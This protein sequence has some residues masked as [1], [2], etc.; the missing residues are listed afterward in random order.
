M[1]VTIAPGTRAIPILLSGAIHLD[2]FLDSCDALFA[3]VPV[4]RRLEI[5]KDPHHGTF[6]LA[7]LAILTVWMAAALSAIDAAHLAAVL[8]FSG[9]TARLAGVSNAL[10]VPYAR[11]DAT[12]VL[13]QRPPFVPLAIEA[14]VLLL[15]GWLTAGLI[16]IALVPGA[17]VTSIGAGALLKRRLGGGLV[18]DVYGFLIVSLEAALLTVVAAG[19]WMAVH[20]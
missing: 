8:A 4:N 7:G 11:L 20:A 2:G 10:F 15:A 12:P 9:A 17:I 18:G 14:I 6:A 19:E 3:T 13:S 5:F 1:L 16:G